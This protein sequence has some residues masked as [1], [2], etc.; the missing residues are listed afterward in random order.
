MHFRL[1]KV[2]FLI[3]SHE[4]IYIFTDSEAYIGYM[5]GRKG[6]WTVESIDDF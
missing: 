4:W 5:D 2:P 6:G 3:S 1:A